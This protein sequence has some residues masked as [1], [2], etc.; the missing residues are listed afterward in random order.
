MTASPGVPRAW[1]VPS[2]RTRDGVTTTPLHPL[3]RGAAVDHDLWA[4]GK[5]RGHTQTAGLIRARGHQ[6]LLA[7]AGRMRFQWVPQMILTP[8]ARNPGLSWVNRDAHGEAAGIQ[9]SLSSQVTR[10]WRPR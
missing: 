4:R 9:E 5:R 1:I 7:P 8:V 10:L 6:D 3:R 2:G